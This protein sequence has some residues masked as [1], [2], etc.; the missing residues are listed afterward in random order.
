MPPP[1]ARG[2]RR[3]YVCAALGIG[4]TDIDDVT[5][6]QIRA[7]YV[8]RC[9]ILPSVHSYTARSFLR[10]SDP[11]TVSG[12]IADDFGLLYECVSFSGTPGILESGIS[13][14]TPEPDIV[15]EYTSINAT[16]R[17]RGSRVKECFL[18]EFST[19]V[20]KHIGV[21]TPCLVSSA[22]ETEGDLEKAMALGLVTRHRDGLGFVDALTMF[23]VSPCTLFSAGCP[24]E[25]GVLSVTCIMHCAY[26]PD[27][28]DPDRR[29]PFVVRAAIPSTP[30]PLDVPDGPMLYRAFTGFM[31]TQRQSPVVLPPAPV[32]V[33]KYVRNRRTEANL[34]VPMATR[35]HDPC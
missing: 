16:P 32:T 14:L 6:K 19:H 17:D 7:A 13:C 20:L 15:H 33:E 24:P 12:T 18:F 28:S 21:F 27:E 23:D 3:D 9:R 31:A 26:Y 1:M 30:G 35:R 22:M 2:V 34:S 11:F 4:C 10:C 29:G 5:D 8:A 25:E